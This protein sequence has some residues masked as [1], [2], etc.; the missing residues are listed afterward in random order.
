[1][2]GRTDKDKFPK[3]ACTRQD[4]ENERQLRLDNKAVSSD[5]SED[6]ENYYLTTVWP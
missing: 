1:M 6:S 5:I 4:V 3:A 2:P